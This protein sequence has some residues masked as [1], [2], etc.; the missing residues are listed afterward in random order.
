[1]SV[2][3]FVKVIYGGAFVYTF[4]CVPLECLAP[5]EAKRWHWIPWNGSYRWLLAIMWVLG[6]EPRS[7]GISTVVLTSKSFST[8]YAFLLNYEMR[9]EL[10]KC[11]LSKFFFFFLIFPQYSR[12]SDRPLSLRPLH[13]GDLVCVCVCVCVCARARARTC[14]FHRG[15][16]LLEQVSRFVRCPK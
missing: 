1:M 4:I 7:S 2:I 11:Y 12:E 9:L 5:S 14:S 8:P 3:F 16:D 10:N 6:L 15:L 13:S